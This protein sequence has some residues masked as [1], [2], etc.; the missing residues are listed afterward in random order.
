MSDDEVAAQVPSGLMFVY[1]RKRPSSRTVH[2]ARQDA[3]RGLC[4][5]RRGD[6]HD[7]AAAADLGPLEVICPACSDALAPGRR[8]QA[9]AERQAD[10]LHEWKA[11]VLVRPDGLAEVALNGISDLLVAV[12]KDVP[13]RR[14][15]RDAR[16]WL[17]PA[18]WSAD[19][20]ASLA[21]AGVEVRVTEQRAV[22]C[23][24]CQQEL[25]LASD[26]EAQQT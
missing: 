7:G 21:N 17:V 3:D 11:S 6:A 9:P 15:D 10:P 23:P 4:G 2:L 18:A 22:L 24:R 16:V 20:A 14:W 8:P 13:G 25:A 19:L 1:A 5:V 26:S 12:I